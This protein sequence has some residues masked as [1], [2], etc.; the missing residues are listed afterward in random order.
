MFSFT[1]INVLIRKIIVKIPVLEINHD[2]KNFNLLLYL[3]YSFLQKRLTCRVYLCLFSVHLL[4]QV[5]G[6]FC[7]HSSLL[8]SQGSSGLGNSKI[9]KFPQKLKNPG[10]KR[11]SIK[12]LRNVLKMK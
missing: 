1:I 9:I 12:K 4:W 11:E 10:V 6:G 3:L 5:G 8:L 7:V 2:I